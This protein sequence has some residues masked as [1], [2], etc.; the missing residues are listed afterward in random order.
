MKKVF[1]FI[2][3]PLKTK[4][5]TYTVA[6]MLVD[7]LQE[8]DGTISTDILTAGDV[9]LGYCSGCWHCMTKGG[10]PQ[11]KQDDMEMLKDRMLGADFII[12]GSPVYAGQVSGQMKTFID[13]LCAWYH[14]IRLAGK[15]GLVV[16]TTAGSGTREVN[17]FMGML[18]S[19]LGVK[20]LAAV[21]AIGYFPGMLGDPEDARKKARE[22]AEAVFLYVTSEKLIETDQNLE[23]CFQA[24]KH[25]IT[26]GSK[27]L[28]ADVEYW[29]KNDMLELG[30][31]GEL[32]KQLRAKKIS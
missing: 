6:K 25:K 23:D 27:W 28:P 9:N 7:R 10:C 24:M 14:L 2:G 8:M 18:L 1:G 3:S 31:Y 12:W 15:P 4:S 26:Y 17:E 13:R 29:R 19:V 21:E 22:A 20:V 5:N 30:S 16:S 11:D 32:L